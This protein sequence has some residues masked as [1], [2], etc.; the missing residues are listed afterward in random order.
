MVLVIC[1]MCFND[2][3][4]IILY[5]LEI[6][7]LSINFFYI[8]NS[9]FSKFVVF[10]SIRKDCALLRDSILSSVF[11]LLLSASHRK[12][13]PRSRIL[14]SSR[15]NSLRV[16]LFLKMHAI[17]CDPLS[18]IWFPSIDNYLMHVKILRSK[19]VS[20]V[21]IVVSRATRISDRVESISSY[22]SFVFL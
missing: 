2:L 9:L 1:F 17:I 8:R 4:C 5:D 12:Y 15:Y 14:F 18:P 19:N 21:L 6:I 20:L 10:Y 3:F 11:L 22:I 7:V 16:S 13:T